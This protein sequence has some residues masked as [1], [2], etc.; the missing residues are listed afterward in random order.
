[1]SPYG[2]SPENA[3]STLPALVAQLRNSCEATA[4]FQGGYTYHA[5]EVGIFLD[6]ARENGFFLEDPPPELATAPWD[7]GNE[8]QVWFQPDSSTFLKATWPDHF[9]MKVIHRPHEEPAASPIDYLERWLWHNQLFGDT[10]EFVS[11]LET[12][13]GLRLIICQPAIEGEPATE[14]EID[15]F[16]TSTG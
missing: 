4:R 2:I 10:V 16:F 13:A 7:E 9:G 5:E 12:D 14:Q 1:M 8:H 6:I 3:G 15:E 11:A